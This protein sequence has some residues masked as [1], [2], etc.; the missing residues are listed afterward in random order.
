MAWLW[1]TLIVLALI[2]SLT[3]I[4][5]SPAERLQ[6]RRRAEALTLGMKVRI[7]TLENWVSERLGQ[8]Q[9]TQY[10]L[11]CD[12]KPKPFAVWRVI[13]REEP[14]VSSP[15]SAS[16]EVLRTTL[17]GVLDDFPPQ[18]L[19]V[20]AEGRMVWVAWN[21]G[22]PGPEIPEIRALLQRIASLPNM[23]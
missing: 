17:H 12:D 13:D 4:L 2:G 11:A 14:W 10:L 1:I 15:K 20:G 18:I 22:G 21:D 6:G 23:N 9:I 7:F 16:W 5:P 19:G 8:E 3:W